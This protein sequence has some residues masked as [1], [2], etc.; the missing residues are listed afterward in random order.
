VSRWP[1]DPRRFTPSPRWFG[2]GVVLVMVGIFA[3]IGVFIWTA[4]HHRELVAEFS[5]VWV[6]PGAG[7]GARLS[8]T[9]ETKTHQF[10]A[11][12]STTRATGD[13]LV[14]GTIDGRPVSGR[15]VPPDFPPWG[16]TVH[17]KLLGAEWTLSTASPRRELTA[18]SD[19][20]RVIRF[21]SA[22]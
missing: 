15:I 5:G 3:V 8:I 9:E 7:G 22:P 13:L 21:S 2:V 1:D 12:E 6:Q 18:T 4:G 14:T 20:G 10:S 17:T 11:D 19:A 16:S